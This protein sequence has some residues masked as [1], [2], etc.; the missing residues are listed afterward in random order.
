MGMGDM[1]RLGCSLKHPLIV[2]FFQ[3][4]EVHSQMTI[5]V[6]L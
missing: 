5:R 3:N 2:N 6:E 4:F 1:C